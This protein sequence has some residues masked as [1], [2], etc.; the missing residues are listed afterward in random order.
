MSHLELPQKTKGI[1]ARRFYEGGG[2]FVR[3]PA[4]QAWEDR[5]REMSRLR[6]EEE[7]KKNGHLVAEQQAIYYASDEYKARKAKED[8]EN[9]GMEEKIAKFDAECYARR[10]AYQAANPV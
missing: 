8:A 6:N 1:I 5:R 4:Q 7:H 2:N 3:T 9:I 10:L